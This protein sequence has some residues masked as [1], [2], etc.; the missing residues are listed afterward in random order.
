VPCKAEAEQKFKDVVEGNE[1][2]LGKSH[3]LTLDTVFSL[4]CLYFRQG[5]LAETQ[6]SGR[7]NK[8]HSQIDNAG[9]HVRKEVL[10]N[11]AF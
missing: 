6:A 2:V 9:S 7:R 4:G 8:T 3:L 10:I 5:N 11:G 1:A